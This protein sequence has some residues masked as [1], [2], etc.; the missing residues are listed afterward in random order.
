M[1]RSKPPRR[2]Y[3]PAPLYTNALER[4]IN[5]AEAIRPRQVQTQIAILRT[6]LDALKLGRG[7]QPL[8]AYWRHLADAGNVAETLARMGLG[9]GAEAQRVITQAQAALAAVWERQQ[10]RGSWTLRAEEMEALHWLL[11]LHATQLQATSYREFE[12]AMAATE[13]RVR[14]ARV[15][16]GPPGT[17]VLGGDIAGAGHPI[18]THH[19]PA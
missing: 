2:R 7:P 11:Q 18:N 5:G 14:Q 6:A 4:A 13:R 1:P 10:T 12:A 17:V 8:C 3:K 19:Q 9:G 16:N 15:G